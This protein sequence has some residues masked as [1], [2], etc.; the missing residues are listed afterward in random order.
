[1]LAL[2]V[3]ASLAVVACGSDDDDTGGATS[4]PT[5]TVID[6]G[7]LVPASAP[8]TVPKPAV[9]VPAESPTEL[10]VTDL[11]VGDGV[12]A[13][14]GDTVVV[15]YV[16]VRTA[17]GETFDNSYDRG[18][19]YDV[20]LGQGNV[21]PG[22]DQG[23]VG[24]QAGGR[25]QLDIPAELAYGDSPP[26]GSNIQPGDAL[27]FVIDA[28]AVVPAVD[29]ADA[30]LDAVPGPSVGIGETTVEEVTAG[31][32]ATLE[33]GQTGIV[34]ILVARGS[35][36]E[37]VFD[38]WELGE[39][40]QVVMVEGGSLPGLLEGLAGMQVGGTRVVTMPPADAF[41][42]EGNPDLEIPGDSDV[43]VVAQLVGI[44]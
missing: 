18:V 13:A 16:G 26:A 21:I 12:A 20:K 27:T 9:S 30:P 34:H 17:D 3:A 1:M 23:L 25:R 10:V 38:T 28:R 44:Y 24:I 8:T 6:E 2:T 42:P 35:D 41:G 32:G 5:G 15:D 37:V 4:A 29:P 33:D 7:T 40:L 43:I 22:W 19:P 14:E 31:D 11:V 36:G 39:P